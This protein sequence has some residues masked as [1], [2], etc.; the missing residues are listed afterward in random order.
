MGHAST[1][2]CYEIPHINHYYW[3]MIAYLIIIEINQSTN[4]S[5]NQ[6]INQLI[7]QSIN[8]LINQSINQSIDQLTKTDNTTQ[9]Y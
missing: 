3:Q 6:S 2:T 8:Q 5:I 1:S 4:Q 7:N 9:A